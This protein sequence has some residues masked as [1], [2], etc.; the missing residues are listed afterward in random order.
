VRFQARASGL[1][2]LIFLGRQPA[3]TGERL[4]PEPGS[5][6]FDRVLIAA[7]AKTAEIQL[8]PLLLRGLRIRLQQVSIEGVATLRPGCRGVAAR[9]PKNPGTH[10]LTPPSSALAKFGG[11]ATIA[12]VS[13]AGDP[14][15]RMCSAK[16]MS[17]MTASS[18]AKAR[19][20][21]PRDRA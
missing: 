21:R 15:G 1:S 10:M 14:I 13:I 11:H 3:G 6:T 4:Q 20:P 16:W 17:P 19:S 18:D 8:L 9:L 7:C 5:V 2:R 12:S